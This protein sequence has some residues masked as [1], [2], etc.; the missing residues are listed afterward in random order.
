M[1]S[2]NAIS[3]Q[4]N[5]CED[6]TKRKLK[7]TIHFVVLAIA[8]GVRSAYMLFTVFCEYGLDDVNFLDE[9][10]SDTVKRPYD[11]HGLDECMITDIYGEEHECQ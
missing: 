9:N 4:R 10:W 7:K 3:I 2:I 6:Y 5:I 11:P 1:Q 8:V